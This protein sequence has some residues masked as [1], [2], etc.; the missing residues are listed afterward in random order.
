MLYGG[1]TG[2]APTA[3]LFSFI[4]WTW[5]W[6]AIGLLLATPIAVCLVTLGRH[7]AA[8]GVL[9]TLL[10]DRPVLD[11][12][13]RFYQR[14]L[15]CDHV[16]TAVI[17]TRYLDDHDVVELC[18]DV[19]VPALEQLQLDHQ[20]GLLTG[21]QLD[22]IS[23]LIERTLQAAAAARREHREED[24]FTADRLRVFTYDGPLDHLLEPM[25]TLVAQDNERAETPVFIVAGL[26][27]RPSRR[28]IELCLRVSRSAGRCEV[29]IGLFAKSRFGD[30]ARKRLRRAG[31]DVRGR[32]ADLIPEHRREPRADTPS[33]PV[34]AIAI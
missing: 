31:F 24:E 12:A 16:E 26:E 9:Y 29:R 8:F 17:A 20:V 34:T 25:L 21:D 6:G 2:V 23:R 13:A 30:V 18:D 22:D 14:I 27:P 3:I 5:L 10:S 1:R 11:A 19:L 28:F 32:L 15:A 4:F 33:Q 7:V